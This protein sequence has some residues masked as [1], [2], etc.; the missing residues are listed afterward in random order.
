MI[1]ADIPDLVK[2][3]GRELVEEGFVALTPWISSSFGEISFG[4]ERGVVRVQMGRERGGV[5]FIQLANSDGRW[6]DPDIWCAA[7]DGTRAPTS[8][9]D[10]A[11]Q[12]QIIRD[13]L[14]E[15]EASENAVMKA[16]IDEVA[17]DRL[18]RRLRLGP[19]GD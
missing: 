8:P 1:D 19:D 4:Y 6:Y 7:L 17:G 3:F 15:I 5:W 11:Q 14:G 2:D 10:L 12:M 13:R 9:S 18:K 16:R